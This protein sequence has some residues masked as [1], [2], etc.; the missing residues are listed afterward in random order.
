M[1]L[2]DDFDWLGGLRAAQLRFP[3]LAEDEHV[4]AALAEVHCL[5]IACHAGTISLQHFMY[6]FLLIIMIVQQFVQGIL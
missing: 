4:K 5:A 2:E 3:A 1:A 6:M